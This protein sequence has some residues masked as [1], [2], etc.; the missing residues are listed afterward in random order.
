MLWHKVEVVQDRKPFA[1]AVPHQDVAVVEIEVV[2]AGGF[3]EADD[4]P[5]RRQQFRGQAPVFT[6]QSDQRDP[7]DEGLQECQVVV[8]IDTAWKT[9]LTIASPAVSKVPK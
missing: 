5:A 9:P 6:P 3:H 7:I 8:A 1:V 2:Q 4:L